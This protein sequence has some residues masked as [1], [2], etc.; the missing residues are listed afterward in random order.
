MH[1][2][3]HMTFSPT[4]YDFSNFPC[5]RVFFKDVIFIT[6][7][8]TESYEFK[9]NYMIIFILLDLYVSCK[10]SVFQIAL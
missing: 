4:L 3:L 6:G 7:H 2:I 5:C 10:F 1:S 8:Y 9:Q